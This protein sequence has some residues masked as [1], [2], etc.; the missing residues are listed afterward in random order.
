MEIRLEKLRKEFKEIVA[1]NDVTITFLDSQV[2]CLLGPSGCGKTTLLRM[3]AGLE[4]PTFGEIYFGDERVTDLLPS[5]RNIGMVF[6]YPV[7]YRGMTVYRNIELPL[8]EDKLTITERRKRVEE[9]LEILGLQEY[10]N[11][12][13]SLLDFGTRQKVAVART[14][15][16]QPEII[17]FDEPLTNVDMDTRVQLK[18]ALKRLAAQLKKTILYVTHDQ[19][20]A[21]TLADQIALMKDGIIV[22]QDKPRELYNYP[23]N[24][25]GG[26]F[27]GN[28]GMDFF[29]YDFEPIDD[30]V[31]R[32]VS[33]LFPNPMRIS[34][35]GDNRRI[36]LGIRPERVCVSSSW[37]PDF[38]Q[39]ELEHKSIVS[40]GQYLLSVKVG[41]LILKA[42]L[43]RETGHDLAN[44]VWIKCPLEWVKVF[45]S[46]GRLL[47]EA[48]LTNE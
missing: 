39:G 46:A 10:A 6:Q 33:P 34:G 48:T 25:F 13:V 38:V 23:N 40:G 21:M 37:Q 43:E 32:L 19:T 14:V 47:R 44:R 26:W 4:T 36:T 8:L 27:L 17:M 18:Q 20:D 41:D 1:V 2:T 3:I 7:V 12:Y 5:K 9:V 22:Q 24:V 28:P 11:W 31:V 45:N 16:R 35:V 15:A 42:K 30:N 29:E